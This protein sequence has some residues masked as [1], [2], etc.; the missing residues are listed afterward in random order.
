VPLRLLLDEHLPRALACALRERRP[1]C[2]VFA[3]SEWEEGIRL[4]AADPD[5]LTA[6]AAQGFTLVTYDQRT[7]VP[8]LRE[9]GEA[10][11]SHCGVIFVDERSLA[12]NDIGGLLGALP[13][14]WDDWNAADWTDRSAYLR[15]PQDPSDQPGG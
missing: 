6:A 3:L 4:G 12:S 13:Q 1:A 10:G 8:L 11:R 15:A 2:D 7:I 9:W 14:L 5:L